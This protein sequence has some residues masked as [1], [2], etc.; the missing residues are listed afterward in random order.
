MKK[1]TLD[2]DDINEPEEKLPVLKSNTMLKNRHQKRMNMFGKTSRVESWNEIEEIL[3]LEKAK[4]KIKKGSAS[5][6]EITEEIIEETGSDER[7]A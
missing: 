3:D 4:K 6:N 2:N 1:D 7:L 5:K